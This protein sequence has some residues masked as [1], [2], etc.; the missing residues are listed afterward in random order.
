MTTWENVQSEVSPV[1]PLSVGLSL[2]ADGVKN[3]TTVSGECWK[4]P[5]NLSVFSSLSFSLS[6]CLPFSFSRFRLVLYQTRVSS[7]RRQ[8]HAHTIIRCFFELAKSKK[9]HCGYTGL[10]GE[11]LFGN[12]GFLTYLWK[13]ARTKI[14][15]WLIM[16][17]RKLSGHFF[18]WFSFSFLAIN[19]HSRPLQER[20]NYLPQLT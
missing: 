6:L 1:N 7:S 16:L 11:E 15:S 4:W 5:L 8:E 20:A 10:Q 2:D 17:W 18:R 9:A 19:P 12:V 14:F 13:P 3:I